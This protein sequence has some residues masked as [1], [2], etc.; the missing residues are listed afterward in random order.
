MAAR[1]KIDLLLILPEPF[2]LTCLDT[3]KTALAVHWQKEESDGLAMHFIN[4]LI[5]HLCIDRTSPPIG[6][7]YGLHLE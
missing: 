6:L 5:G 1:T 4:Y 7:V 3:F 2:F